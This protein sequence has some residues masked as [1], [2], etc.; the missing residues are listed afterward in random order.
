M[1]NT[2]PESK[3]KLLDYLIL[4]LQAMDK[5]ELMYNLCWL[6]WKKSR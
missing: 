2:L 1:N 4:L 5:Q 3:I 6:I